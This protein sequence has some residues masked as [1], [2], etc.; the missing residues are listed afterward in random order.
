MEKITS[1]FSPLTNKVCPTVDLLM[2]ADSTNTHARREVN[3]GPSHGKLIITE[4]QTAGRGRR[5]KKWFS[6][7]GGG[8][9]DVFGLVF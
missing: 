3:S 7:L 4:Y 8:Y 6:P 1:C 2:V 9:N 5:G